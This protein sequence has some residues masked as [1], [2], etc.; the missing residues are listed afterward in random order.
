[1]TDF[2]NSLVR[3]AGDFRDQLKG[4]SEY[5]KQ[6]NNNYMDNYYDTMYASSPADR[7][8]SE[9]K[10]SKKRKYTFD[11]SVMPGFDREALEKRTGITLP[12]Y[13]SYFSEARSIAELEDQRQSIAQTRDFI[14]QSGITSLIGIDNLDPILEKVE[15]NDIWGIGK[16]LCFKANR[17]KMGWCKND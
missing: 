4:S 11:S 9:G 13:E 12:D 14:Y 10:V 7:T 8:D 3:S 5:T 2:D 17:L 15:I 16:L 1:M 6:F